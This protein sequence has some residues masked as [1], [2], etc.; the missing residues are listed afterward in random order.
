MSTLL[1]LAASAAICIVIGADAFTTSTPSNSN[2]D[3]LHSIGRRNK[4]WL[5]ARPTKNHQA[6][7][8]APSLDEKEAKQDKEEETTIP[9]ITQ[10]FLELTQNPNVAIVIDVEN[11]RGKTNFEL[12]H[13]DFSR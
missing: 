6:A 5:S 8:V 7:S 1:M 2:F 9:A 10:R 12:D 4:V 3:V 11:V 13:A